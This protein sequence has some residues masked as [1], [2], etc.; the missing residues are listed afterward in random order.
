MTTASPAALNDW[1]IGLRVWLERAGTAV[2]GPGRYELLE[3]IDRWHSISAAARNLGMSYRHTWLMVQT[4][5]EAAGQPLVAAAIGGLQGGGAALTPFGRQVLTVFREVQAHLLH[6]A[7]ALGPRLQQGGAEDTIHIAAAVSLDVVLGQLLSDYARHKPKVRVRAIYGAS[8]EL[9]EH[10]LA[11]A[12]LDLFVTADAHQLKHLQEAGAVEPASLT[13]LAENSLAAVGSS[14]GSVK[15]RNS[16]DLARAER[17]ALAAPSTPL[18][19][20]TR[21]YLRQQGL[22]DQ[23]QERALLVDNSRGVMTAVRAGQ[24]DVGLTYGSDVSNFPDC[25]V[26]FR[27][28][29]PPIKIRFTA[30]L[31]RRAQHPAAARHFLDF[32]I[33]PQ[34]AER[35]RR[36]GFL[37]AG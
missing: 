5:N 3:G 32:L 27:V 9:A 12:P 29:R 17:I 10:L 25:R 30:A 7:D 15:V 11:G 24:A 13:D 26:L 18:G 4:M 19:R 8:D 34:A 2:L 28:A 33:S 23:L 31:V 1:T 22:Y 16:A 6:S 35:F 14:G 20:Y 37:P 21:L 36:C